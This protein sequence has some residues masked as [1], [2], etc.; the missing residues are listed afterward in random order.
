MAESNS[1]SFNNFFGNTRRFG[2]NVKVGS[3]NSHTRTLKEIGDVAKKETAQIA[4]PFKNFLEVNED[5]F[6]GNVQNEILKTQAQMFSTSMLLNETEEKV[7][8]KAPR[9]DASF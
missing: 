3:Q 7:N 5:V 1:T 9:F 8:G 4:N 6:N 2:L